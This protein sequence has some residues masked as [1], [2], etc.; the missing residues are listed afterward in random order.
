MNQYRFRLNVLSLLVLLSAAVH[1]QDF[2]IGNF[3]EKPTDLSA[4][5]SGVKDMNQKPAAL[6]RLLATTT[7][8]S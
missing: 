2:Q 3:Y 8:P 5:T 1:A 7:A 6:I 4:A